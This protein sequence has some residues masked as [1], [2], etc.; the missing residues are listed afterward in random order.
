[1][2]VQFAAVCKRVIELAREK[3]VGTELPADLFMAG[4]FPADRQFT[5]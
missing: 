5:I 2:G 4:E 1:M 3:K